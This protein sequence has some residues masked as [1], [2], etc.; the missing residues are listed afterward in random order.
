[1]IAAAAAAAAGAATAFPFVSTALF[2]R[3]RLRPSCPRRAAAGPSS[4]WE[5]REDARWLR[6]EQ[7]WLRE[8]QRWL[9]E[10]SR[11]RAEREALLAEVAALRLRLRALEGTHPAD[12]LAVVSVDAVVA[13]PAPQ[14]RPALVEEVEVRKEVV[15]VEEKKVAV[16]A[17]AEAGSGAGDSSKSRRT[18]RAGAEGEDV[19]AMQEALLKL[20]FYSGEEDMEYSSFSSGTERAVKTWQSTVGTSENGVMTSELLEWLF[21]GKTGEDAKTK[22]GTNGA[23]VPSVT[24][25]AEVQK[26]VITE[27]GVAGAGVSEHRVFLLGENRWEDPTRLTQNKKPV[28]TGTTA[29][30][31]AC[32]SCRGEG[33][34]MCL[35]C[36]GTGEPNIEPQ[37]LEWVGEDT[38]CPYCEGLGSILCDVCDGKKVMAS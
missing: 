15:V 3:P 38:K 36:D 23:A 29:S 12:H 20:G 22:D 9:R 35:E 19:R 34:L 10:E 28:S 5:E 4:S 33:R 2:H 27:N 6:E 31:K 7:R 1:M 17:K 14:P 8:E 11:W 37:F 16:A 30:T 18:L 21:S 13:S 32:I 25:I 26:T 24:G